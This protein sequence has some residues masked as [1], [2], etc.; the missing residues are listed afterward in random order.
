MKRYR[1]LFSPAALSLVL[2]FFLASVPG[3]A[4]DLGLR[5]ATLD[6][7]E[8]KYAGKS[9]S[10][11]FSQIS[12]LK[13]LDIT[14]T[15]SGKAWFSHPG[16]MRWLYTAPDRHEII[17][18]GKSVWIY[19]P[20]Q[21]QVMEGNASRF[22]KSGAG[23]A[24]LSDIGLIRKNFR[25]S[26]RGTDPAWVEL[27]L[28]TKAGAPADSDSGEVSSIILRVSRDSHE[29]RRITTLNAHGDATLFEFSNILFAPLEA[30]FFDFKIPEGA[31]IIEME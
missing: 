7:L 29:I 3:F 15:A 25:I 30:G 20:E 6:N 4:K 1:S 8:K 9:F 18:N 28:D 13:V 23:G 24:F 21:N 14:E 11:D 2:W 19:R 26:V 12:T 16:K 27:A 10:A 22:F 5:D 31:S 17:T